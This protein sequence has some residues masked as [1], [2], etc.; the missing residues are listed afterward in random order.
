MIPGVL[1]ALGAAVTF[2]VFQIVNARILSRTDVYLATRTVLIV[3]TVA[4]GSI[5]IVTDGFG[6]WSQ[7]S[8]RALLMSGAAGMLHF[9]L[10]WTLLGMGQQRIGAARTGALLG[11][12]PLFGALSAWVLLGERLVAGQ[13]VG[14]LVV[15]AGVGVIA[16]ATGASRTVGNRGTVAGV[17]AALGTALCWALSP[18]F[19][20]EALVELPS[21]SAAATVGLFTSAVLYTALIRIVRRGAGPR[22]DG[23]GLSGMFGLGGL[24]VA[25]AL[26][27]QWTAFERT[28]VATVLVTLQ[29]TPALMPM[30]AR[31]AGLAGDAVRMLPVYAGVVGIVSGSLLV[32]LLG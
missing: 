30:L 3:G 6:P 32:I 22:L 5:T 23:T 9:F 13:V 19:I 24:L 28:A 27:L 4:L 10:G 8:P 7:A 1:P 31:L 15:T 11:A 14:L 17:A 29:L 20:R 18:T 2:A 21:P 25:V 26:W 16:T 12:V